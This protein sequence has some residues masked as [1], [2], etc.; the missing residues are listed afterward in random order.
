MGKL[1]LFCLQV[2]REK[3]FAFMLPAGRGGGESAADDFFVPE[4]QLIPYYRQASLNYR[5]RWL[6][7][8]KF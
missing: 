7:T 8:T 6:L 2:F 5:H 4:E 1:Y 3:L